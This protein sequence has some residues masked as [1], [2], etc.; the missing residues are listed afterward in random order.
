MMNDDLVIFSLMENVVPE[1]VYRLKDQFIQ[2][3]A[4]AENEIHLFAYGSYRS[5]GRDIGM[6]YGYR[7][8]GLT[9]SELTL[10]KIAFGSYDIPFET[11]ASMDRN[12]EWIPIPGPFEDY[13]LEY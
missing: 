6:I 7:V 5:S 11:I 4:E 10:W 9:K 12:A 1:Y 3:A 13:R 2:W 8:V